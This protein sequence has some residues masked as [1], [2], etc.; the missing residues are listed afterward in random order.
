M[1][2]RT[3]LTTVPRSPV[4]PDL[5]H[6]PVV[7]EGVVGDEVLDV[8][9][10]G[11]ILVAPAEHRPRHVGLELPLNVPHEPDAAGAV[12]LL[13]LEI[14]QAVGLRAAVVRVVPRRA[15]PVVLVEEAV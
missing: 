4:Q 2:S 15:T 1:S 7:V 14:D 6:A 12:E 13:G 9:P 3:A 10:L 11:E 8:R 5:L